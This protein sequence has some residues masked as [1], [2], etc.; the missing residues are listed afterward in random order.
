MPESSVTRSTKRGGSQPLAVFSEELGF[1]EGFATRSGGQQDPHLATAVE[2]MSTSRPPRQNF[3]PALALAFVAQAEAAL[4]LAGAD[5]EAAPFSAF[6][7]E[8]KTPKGAVVNTLNFKVHGQ[9]VTLRPRFNDAAAVIRIDMRRDHPSAAPHATQGWRDYRPLIESIFAMAPEARTRF[10]EHIWST[11]VIA[12]PERR[13]ATK[14]ERVVRPFERVLA[15]FET[16]GSTP[17]GALFQALVFGYF[18]AD[19][20]NLTLESHQVN[21]G[22][23]RVDMPGD[24]AGFRGGEVELA[25]EVKDYGISDATVESVLIDFLEDLVEAPNTTA[26]VVADTVDAA[27][28]ERLEQSNVVALS[29]ADLRERVVTWDLPKQQEALRGAIYYLSRV[30][31]KTSL[32]DKLLGFLQSEHLDAGIVDQPTLKDPHAPIADGV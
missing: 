5:R 6:P 15:E 11:G 20:P 7:R 27:A 22:S 18:S 24:V 17:G 1:P 30:Q 19:S 25:I 10:A 3:W 26:V 9:K 32:V 28:R 14:A 4:E 23:S 2:W 29:R 12:A 31:K 16:Q 13:W 8:E 21:T